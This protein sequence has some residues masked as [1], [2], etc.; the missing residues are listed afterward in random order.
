MGAVAES[1]RTT[2]R[3][4]QRSTHLPHPHRIEGTDERYEACPFDRLDMV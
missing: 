1:I 3:D 4:S 2:R